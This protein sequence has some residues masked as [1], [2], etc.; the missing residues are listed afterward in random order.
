MGKTRLVEELARGAESSG[1][2]VAT[3]G[4]SALADAPLPYGPVVAVVDAFVGLR[5][6]SELE[7][8]LGDA[9]PDLAR[10]DPALTDRLANAVPVPMP[11]SMI[12]ARVFS[13]VRTL[14]ERRARDRALLVVFEDLHWADPASLDL[15]GYLIRNRGWPGAIVATY[16]SDELHRRHPLVPWLAEIARV[17]FVE[18]IE[19][20]RLDRS[21]VE[22]QVGAILGRTPDAAL[23][24]ELVRRADGNARS[25]RRSCSP[26]CSRTGR[27]RGPPASS[28]PLL[29]RIASLPDI[30]RVRRS[31]RCAVAGSPGD[32]VVSPGC[33]ACPSADVED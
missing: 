7:R 16:R 8:L 32:A 3:G 23:V 27:S 2:L 30:A 19:L 22:A 26:P 10:I 14:I 24:D 1:M 4:C 28:Q 15:I 21:D 33:S 9:G 17:P 12:A 5:R 18:R 11:A 20:R 31:R 6:R 29:A 13:A 25:S